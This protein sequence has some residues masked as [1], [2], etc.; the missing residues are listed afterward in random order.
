MIYAAERGAVTLTSSCVQVVELKSHLQSRGL[1]TSGLKEDLVAR[2]KEADK[3]E[4]AAPENRSNAAGAAA[5]PAIHTTPAPRSETGAAPHSE[6][7]E[8]KRPRHDAKT[9]T[10]GMKVKTLYDSF[11]IPR[12]APQGKSALEF[13]KGEEITIADLKEEEGKWYAVGH[14][15]PFQWFP[16][17]ATDWK[18][19]SQ[20][21]DT[22]R[23]RDLFSST[24]G[25]DG[26]AHGPAAKKQRMTFEAGPVPVERVL[27]LFPLARS[28]VVVQCGGRQA[29]G[30]GAGSSV[31]TC[32]AGERFEVIVTLKTPFGTVPLFAE[33]MLRELI[34]SL[35]GPSSLRKIPAGHRGSSLSPETG[36]VSFPVELTKAAEDVEISVSFMYKDEPQ[37]IGH[38]V[39]VKVLPGQIKF[40]SLQAIRVPQ[41][42][43]QKPQ[44]QSSAIEVG[45]TIKLVLGPCTKDVH[46]NELQQDLCEEDVSG[47]ALTATWRCEG[48]MGNLRLMPPTL[49][50][51]GL[52]VV[53]GEVSLSLPGHHVFQVSCSAQQLT[54]TVHVE[55]GV[56]Q[57]LKM[58]EEG[59]PHVLRRWR[60]GGKALVLNQH[61]HA[62]RFGP[63]D[64]SVKMGLNLN[65]C[66]P[67]QEQAQWI[68]VKTRQTE[69]SEEIQACSLSDVFVT[70]QVQDL[71]VYVPETDNPPSRGTY[72]LRPESDNVDS[73][74]KCEPSMIQ[75]DLP[76]DPAQWQA[77]DLALS[78]RREGFSV[79]G[80]VVKD[81]FDVEL[82]GEDL[83]ASGENMWVT[84]KDCLLRGTSFSNREEK[85][86]AHNRLKAAAKSLMEKHTLA[87][88]G[89]GKFRSSVAKCISETDLNVE[90][91]PFDRGGQSEIFRGH[92]SGTV[93]AIKVPLFQNR[94][95]R[96]CDDTVGM[97]MEVEKELSVT[98]ACSHPHVVQI[99]GLM[100]GAGRIGIVMECADTSL[101][102]HIQSLDPMQPVD[103]AE[104]V[105]LLM[106]GAAGLSFIHT[107]KG[108]T[109]GDVKPDNLLIQ[110][111]KLKVSDFGLATVR[112]TMTKFT[113]QMRKGTSY[114]M[115][116]EMLLG[117]SGASHPRID[118][119]GFGCVI[120]NV[121]T[122]EIPLSSCKSENELVVA[123]R[124]RLP[125]FTKGQEKQGCPKLLLELIDLCCNYETSRRPTMEHVETQLRQIFELIQ[126]RDGFQ[127]PQLWLDQG[128]GLKDSAWRMLVRTPE[129]LDFRLIQQRLE[130][131]FGSS[132]K[133]LKIEMNVNVDLFRRYA[134]ERKKISEE[135]SGDANEVWLWH[136]TGSNLE[137][138]NA[139]LKDGF[140]T[141]Y[142]GLDFEYYGAGIVYTEPQ[143]YAYGYHGADNQ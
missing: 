41:Y 99:H 105:R 48:K 25:N 130:S 106:D 54:T 53:V 141:N 79:V 114:F 90:A 43:P 44:S 6:A 124:Q 59:K 142:C 112:R 134:L 42:S 80:D 111:G 65:D 70:T 128:C 31:L 35:V 32:R 58:I 45:E 12:G 52:G 34:L 33:R 75:L 11:D 28:E 91:E 85:D 18:K 100:V 13:V 47:L 71:E 116:P 138:E 20:V 36:V 84:L 49:T 140:D 40:E 62:I 127:L 125:V 104:T 14:L 16:L 55:C 30:A 3:C 66:S 1:R 26:E 122:G 50:G 77:R 86:S 67:S 15:F 69:R 126:T 88:L 118:V 8:K 17:S 115:A 83:I 123:M 81:E 135:N 38:G 95:L 113:G 57:S 76:L 92:H 102:K 96:V 82:S 23:K 78:L 56:P 98:K 109:H 121:V 129:S 63:L 120:A 19:T 5:V 136:A 4:T 37:M 64:L 133:I 137:T 27:E 139:I 61:G 2:L 101:A 24:D 10:I 108:T 94:G 51:V 46:G 131:E 21:P 22:S 110:Q 89:K 74:L 68:H 39:T 73:S 103:W 7:T 119:W 132:V 117:E 87:S 60:W 107:H 9:P 97:M 72:S 93:V 143:F 29:G